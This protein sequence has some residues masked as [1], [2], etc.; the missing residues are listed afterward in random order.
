MI[1]EKDSENSD[2]FINLKEIPLN[3][4]T[5]TYQTAIIMIG[6]VVLILF[7]WLSLFPIFKLQLK[8][9]QNPNK[10]I[11]SKS[12][13]FNPNGTLNRST[14]YINCDYFNSN[15]IFNMTLKDISNINKHLHFNIEF[16]NKSNSTFDQSISIDYTLKAWNQLA[17]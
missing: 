6:A 10:C 7:G 14:G 2:D 9:N 8:V 15:G 4:N 1:P 16:Y 17:H 5:M 3:I 11:G 12:V 13:S